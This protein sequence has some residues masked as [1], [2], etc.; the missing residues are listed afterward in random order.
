MSDSFL[1]N[2]LDDLFSPSSAPALMTTNS[3][4]FSIEDFESGT[5]LPDAN[6]KVNDPKITSMNDDDFLS[7]LD[8]PP[9]APTDYLLP[10]T[11]T[12]MG[13]VETFLAESVTAQS[14]SVSNSK[15]GA[16]ATRL[17]SSRKQK[18]ESELLKHIGSGFPDSSKLQD[19]VL[20]A[21]YIPGDLRYQVW[22]ILI[23]GS[24]SDDQEAEFW[25]STGKELPNYVDVVLDCDAVLAT[26]MKRGTPTV[27]SDTEKL[28][29]DMVDIIVL[30]CVRRSV[31]YK[32]MFSDIA[33]L[34]VCNSNSFASKTLSSSCFYS[35]CSSFLPV[36][37]LP[38][39]FFECPQRTMFDLMV[40]H[41]G[42]GP[43]DSN[44]INSFM[45]EVTSVVSLPETVCPF[46]R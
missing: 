2:Q 36:I 24:Y 25:R 10:K 13:E 33:S 31:P 42:C 30:Y 15:G 19:L 32:P 39:L 28:R 4:S 7:W 29:A 20:S 18:Y 16:K 12:P 22:S 23:N 35:I 43:R 8:G 38:V 34:L 44:K 41:I 46:R 26:R 21:G 45:A 9:A 37:N 3:A 14:S 40:F 27:V 6:G 1:A 11:E 17:K 5:C